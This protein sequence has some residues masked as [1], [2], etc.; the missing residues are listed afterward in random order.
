MLSTEE[1]V[2]FSLLQEDSI[3]LV[4]LLL[5]PV[6]KS[7]SSWPKSLPPWMLWVVSI[8]ASTN[9]EVL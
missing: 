2:N 1:E 7:L 6:F 3:T 9:V 5:S 4:S 8:H